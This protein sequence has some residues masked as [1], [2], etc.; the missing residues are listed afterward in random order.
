M[1]TSSVHVWLT[2]SKLH[3]VSPASLQRGTSHARFRFDMSNKDR[4]DQYVDSSSHA[5]TDAKDTGYS[6][7]ASRVS[8]S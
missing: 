3:A 1:A 7:C 5:D 4:A 6:S 8:R 2:V